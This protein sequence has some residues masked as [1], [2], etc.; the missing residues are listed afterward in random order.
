MRGIEGARN[1]IHAAKRNF[2]NLSRVREEILIELKNKL[3]QTVVIS[4]TSIE[5]ISHPTF[6]T[7]IWDR[8]TASLLKIA[9]A[10]ANG[11]EEEQVAVNVGTT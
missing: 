8:S 1:C 4:D 2:A 3:R 7:L 11:R 9:P 10:S 6:E 5:A